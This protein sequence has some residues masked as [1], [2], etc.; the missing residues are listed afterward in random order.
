MLF[1]YKFYINYYKD[2][3]NF[4]YEEASNHFLKHG[5][6]EKRIANEKL[7]HFNY[8]FYINYYEDLK[9]FSFINACTHFLTK[10]IEES[11]KFNEKLRYFD[12]NFYI[13]YYEDLKELSFIDARTHFLTNGIKENRKFN[14][15]LKHFDY[16]FYINYNEDIKELSF[17]DACNHFL[18]HGIEENRIINFNIECYNSLKNTKYNNDTINNLKFLHITKTGGTS[19]EEFAAKIGIKWS[20]YDKTFYEKFNK[21]GYW[22]IPLCYFEI[23]TIKKYNWFT[24]VR[25][26]YNRIVSEINYLIKDKYIDINK[27][28]INIYLNNILTNIIIDERTLN[29]KFIELNNIMYKFH[30]IPMYFYTCYNDYENIIPNLTIIKFENLNKEINKFLNKLNIEETFDIHRNINDT[31]IFEFEDLSIKNIK[32][33][34]KIYKK[35]FELFNYNIYSK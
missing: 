26:P 10:G 4:S 15:K 17:I 29:K 19:I 8:D 1:D 12:Y 7:I 20:K 35:D 14:E 31:K 18:K 25:N 9:E 13:N 27:V 30:F 21:E 28:D 5:I 33:I 11:R 23:E 2:L 16:N 34:N 24:I 3:K 32:L 6:E 22:H